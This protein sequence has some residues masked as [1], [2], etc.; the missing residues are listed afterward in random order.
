MCVWGVCVGVCDRARARERERE[1]GGG[2]ERDG[3]VY[4]SRIFLC[5]SRPGCSV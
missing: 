3:L 4:N 2:G 5:L 1:G